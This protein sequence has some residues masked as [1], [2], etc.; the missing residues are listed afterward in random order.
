MR[1]EGTLSWSHPSIFWRAW[2][3]E[4]TLISEGQLG[5]TSSVYPL[6]SNSALHALD[7]C[8]SVRIP[9]RI[10]MVVEL[11]RGYKVKT[12]PLG[13]DRHGR[14]SSVCGYGRR[15]LKKRKMSLSSKSAAAEFP[16]SGDKV[17]RRKRR[18]LSDEQ[19]QEIVEAFNLFDT[20]KDQAIDYHELKVG[21]FK[22][23]FLS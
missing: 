5:P 20:D 3:Q 9:R 1:L 11:R 13:K 7:A 19:K 2:P 6:H 16:G 15:D 21:E 4:G 8:T 10:N 17:R 14:K 22:S 12:N 23:S 18:E